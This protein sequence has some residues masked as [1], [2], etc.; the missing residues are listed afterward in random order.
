MFDIDSALTNDYTPRGCRKATTSVTPLSMPPQKVI[1]IICWNIRGITDKIFDTDIQKLLF[2]NDIIL[3][4]ETHTG[5]LSETIYNTIPGFIY[6]DFPRKFVHPHAPGPSGG[7]GIFIKSDI[8]EGIDLDCTDESIVWLKLKSSFFDWETDK[9]ISCA[10]F[11]PIDSSYIQSTNVRT[12]YFNILTEQ[13]N[14]F[15][16]NED[17]FI[18]GDLNARTGQLN[19]FLDQIPGTDGGLSYF[20]NYDMSTENV[21][22]VQKRFS[23]DLVVK[24]YGR[25]L[26]DF[27]K[28]S[29]YCIMNGRVGNVNNTG[30]YTCYKENG[31]SVVDYLICKPQCMHLI[32]DYTIIP[33]RAVSDHRPFSFALSCPAKIECDNAVLSGDT[34]LSYKWDESKVQIYKNNLGGTRCQEIQNQLMLDIIDPNLNCDDLSDCFYNLIDTAIK[35][36]FVERGKRKVNPKF[37]NNKW[38]N[39]ECKKRKTLVNSYANSHNISISPYSETYHRL[40]QEYN[41]ARQKY[42]RQYKDS[43]RLKLNNFHSDNPNAFWKLWKSLNPQPVNNSNL[44][45]SQ[46]DTYCKEQVTPPPTEYFDEIHMKEIEYFVDS[47]NAGLEDDTLSHNSALSDE[48][49]NSPITIDEIET[50]L[51]K[52]KN[53]KAAGVDGLSGEFLKYVPDKLGPMLY[54]LYNCILNRGE[55]PTKWAEGIIHP[56]HKKASINDTDNYRKITVMP[57][58]GKVLESILNSRLVFRNL[59]LEMDDPCQFGFKANARTSDNL[60]ILQSL[61]NRQKFKNK[62]LYVCFVDFTK[63]FDYVNRL[64]LYYKLIKRGIKGKMLNLVC[65]MYKK[66]KCRVKW[67]GKLGGHIDS[68]F[69]VLQGGMLSPKLFTEFL[70]DLKNYLETECGL[71][72]DDDILA[73][74]LYADDL[75]LCS[76]SPE[77]LQKLIDGLFEFCKKW[78][79]IVSLAKTNVLV[80]GKRNPKDKFIF[81]F[82]E[83]EIKITTEYKYVGAVVSTKTKDMFGKNH[84]HLAEKSKNAIYALKSYSENA[85][86][87]LQPYLAIK[88]FDSQIAPIM[89]YTTEVWFQNKEIPVLE[90]IHLNYLKNTMRVKP[91]SSTK[92]IYAECGRFPL[93]IKQKCQMIKYWKRVVG[94]NKNYIVKKAYNSTLELHDHGQLN[95]CTS[96]KSILNEAQLQQAWENQSMDDKQFA[97]LKECLHRSYMDQCLENIHDLNVC[98]KLR[99]YKLFKEEFKFENYL[100]STKNLNHTLSLFRFRISSHNLR[101][102]TGRYSRPK[103]PENERI[104]I[105]CTSQAIESESHFL[106]NCNL[107]NNERKE[108]L[109]MITRYLPDFISTPNTQK[110]VMLMSAK[111]KSITDALGKFIFNCLKKRNNTVLLN[112]SG[113]STQSNVNITSQSVQ[114][115]QITNT[116]S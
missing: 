84:D 25:Y 99:T 21:N 5:K 115:V 69:G 44:L 94:M 11:S 72:I 108:L 113:Q 48:I 45:L 62:P 38:F 49:C 39:A 86:G 76:D 4:N 50:H 70:T 14:K 53:H 116:R 23:R 88:M 66:A 112:D 96:V 8:M 81:I 2:T 100:L 17:I 37:P 109:E 91:S 90:K 6:R 42:K 98:P 43:I 22:M 30:D 19:D 79:L 103:T 105:Y 95:W 93:I 111:E 101:I 87:Q 9:I 97:S 15:T 75:I 102:E 83:S 18:C 77:G 24:E 68:T 73:Y 92:A 20:E 10:Y 33:K 28:S 65:D 52:L 64:A 3:L 47:F 85:V 13:V 34:Q 7:I 46:F 78:H 31:A 36:T 104:C 26:I 29:G 89:Q 16:N 59:S 82:N 32:K 67:K 61:V 51:K 27:C 54:A 110:F 40:E 35:G 106:L 1:K 57:A 80:F 55:W 63:A 12:D 107:Y 58:L 56:V 74:I 71:L 41:K 60:F 114:F